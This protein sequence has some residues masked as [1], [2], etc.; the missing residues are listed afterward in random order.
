M[1]DKKKLGPVVEIEPDL[2]QSAH[3]DSGEFYMILNQSWHI[4]MRLDPA[5]GLLLA[6]FHIVSIDDLA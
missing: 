2:A 5:A 6:L 4:W 1:E 3:A